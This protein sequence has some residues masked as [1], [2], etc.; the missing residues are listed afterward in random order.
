MNQTYRDATTTM[1][2]MKVNLEN[3]K[4]VAAGATYPHPLLAVAESDSL[5]KQVTG[6]TSW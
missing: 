4:L 1:E 3:S 2:E 6:G 5:F